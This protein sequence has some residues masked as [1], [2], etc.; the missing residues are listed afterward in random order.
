MLRCQSLCR[1]CVALLYLLPS[2]KCTKLKFG[3]FSQQATPL[4]EAAKWGRVGAV[5]YLIQAGADVNI[6]DNDWVSKTTVLTGEDVRSR[7]L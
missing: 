2:T 7:V 6:K 1:S 4:H 3:V 5:E